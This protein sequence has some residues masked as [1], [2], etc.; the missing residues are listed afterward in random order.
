MY[1]NTNGVTQNVKE[2]LKHKLINLFNCFLAL[3]HANEGLKNTIF[4]PITDA[5]VVR[6]QFSE[7]D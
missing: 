7:F 6:K 3:S 4:Q 2:D 1:H 5:A